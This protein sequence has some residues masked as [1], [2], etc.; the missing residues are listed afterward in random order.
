MACLKISLSGRQ[1]NI[2]QSRRANKKT[3]ILEVTVYKL[4]YLWHNSHSYKWEGLYHKYSSFAVCV[5]LTARKME[6]KKCLF[7]LQRKCLF[8][9]QCLN[10]CC[11]LKPFLIQ[12]IQITDLQVHQLIKSYPRLLC[13]LF[14]RPR[15]K[16]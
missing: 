13:T 7:L 1:N 8:C 16:G 12:F 10:F 3:C 6:R 11:F 4:E 9:V 2:I 14:D 15:L 5:L